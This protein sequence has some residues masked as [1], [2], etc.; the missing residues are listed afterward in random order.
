MGERI[1]ITGASGLIGSHLVSELKKDHD[2]V[3]LVHNQLRGR[4]LQ[5]ALDGTTVVQADIRD[6][7][8]LKH[9]M[10]RYYVNQ[11]V[12]CAAV[13]Q[14][15]SAFKDPLSTYDINIMGVVAV[16][17]AARQLDVERVLVMQ[18]D[19]VYGEKLG[20]TVEDPYQPS[21]PYATS[22]ICQ[23]FIA[24]SYIDTYGMDI[25][26]P[27]S[28]NTFGYDPFSNRIFPNTIKA[29]LRG[30]QPLIF[31]NDKS[32]R[33]YIYVEDLVN[34]LKQL[35]LDPKLKPGPYNIATGWV[36][37]QEEIVKEVLKHF[38]SIRAEYKR[39]K[40]P[41][42]IQEQT[43]KMTKW[44]W[45]PDWNFNDAVERTITLF[46]HYKEDWK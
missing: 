3:S 26:I 24:W 21:E 13:A 45:K 31:T 25:I 39:V 19:K 34:A 43:M 2:V 22:K 1:L 7:N 14:V 40:L 4:W 15:K 37:N 8:S 28:C 41:H 30:E 29:C 33:E 11:V 20:A 6:F 42:Q 9:I 16:L 17:E 5:K 27:H 23:G 12:H 18:T 38:P 10:A 36:Q 35:L 32:I 44:N 46:E